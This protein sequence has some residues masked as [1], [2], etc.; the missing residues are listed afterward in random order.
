MVE[1][2]FELESVRWGRQIMTNYI[3]LLEIIMRAGQWQR[4]VLWKQRSRVIFEIQQPTWR[5]QHPKWGM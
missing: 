5:R 1:P 4:G 3:K 2:N